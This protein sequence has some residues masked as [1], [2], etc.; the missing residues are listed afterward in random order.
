MTGRCGGER[1][2]AVLFAG[3]GAQR[4]GMGRGLYG[5]FPVFTRVFDEVCAEAR[6]TLP[7][8]AE[9]R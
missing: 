5:V 1:S 3:Q 7:L 8:Q 6:D 4:L 2:V 9:A